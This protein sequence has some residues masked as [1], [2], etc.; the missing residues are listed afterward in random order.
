[1]PVLLSKIGAATHR[2]F[3]VIHFRDS[4]ATGAVRSKSAESGGLRDLL[5]RL[6]ESSLSLTLGFRPVD[7]AWHTR[8]SRFNGLPRERCFDKPLKRLFLNHASRAPA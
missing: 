2:K 7:I 3:A 8:F 5:G 1:M 6:T 4:G